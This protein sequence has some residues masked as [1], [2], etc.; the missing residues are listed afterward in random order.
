MS[1]AAA[2]DK[3]WPPWYDLDAPW[4]DQPDLDEQGVQKQTPKTKQLKWIFGY[5]EKAKGMKQILWERGMWL[6]GM[7]AKLE[8]D[9]PDYPEL[10]EKHVLEKCKDFRE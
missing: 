5:A 7:K 3:P 1:F 6:K 8:D 10:S 9:H 4:Y 2:E